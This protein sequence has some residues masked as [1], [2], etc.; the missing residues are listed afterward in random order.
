MV[1]DPVGIDLGT[2][3]QPVCDRG[4]GFVMVAS[5]YGEFGEAELGV[6]GEGGRASSSW[7]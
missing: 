6:M 7:A 3:S 1:K 4:G 5:P 2:P